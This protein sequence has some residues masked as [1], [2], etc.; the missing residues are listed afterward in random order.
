MKNWVIKEAGPS[1]ENMYRMCVSQQIERH[2]GA[3]TEDFA[4]IKAFVEFNNTDV[5][6]KLHNSK[7]GFLDCI[8]QVVNTMLA[9]LKPFQNINENVCH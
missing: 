6:W 3:L 1:N 7:L 4:P 5:V 2:S 8:W 9:F